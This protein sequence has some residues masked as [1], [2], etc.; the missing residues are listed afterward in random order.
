MILTQETRNEF[1]ALYPGRDVERCL[2]DFS[3]WLAKS[4]KTATH[5]NQAFLGFAKGWNPKHTQS[6]S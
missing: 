5:P 3:A 6:A 2:A 1:A 4:G